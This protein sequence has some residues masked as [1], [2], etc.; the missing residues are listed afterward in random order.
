MTRQKTYRVGEHDEDEESGESA[1]AYEIFE[2]SDSRSIYSVYI[3]API[4][5]PSLYI[6]LFGLLRN[7]Q[8]TDVVVFYLNT[9]GGWLDTGIQ[10][11][12]AIKSCRAHVITVLD[13]K[14]VSMGALLF[15]AGDERVVNDN[16]MLMFHT[17]SGGNTTGKSNE[18]ASALAASIQHYKGVLQS[19]TEGFLTKEEIKEIMEG[20]D[21][22]LSAD[23]VRLRLTKLEKEAAEKAKPAPAPRRRVRKELGPVAEP[24]VAS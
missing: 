11:L 4:G 23:N 1:I 20:K 14:A 22:W 21:L 18:Q 9:P 3:S 12:N 16:T 7:A 5:A 6:G 19:Y 10:L 2:K 8:E 17:Y 15:M 24:P 13:G